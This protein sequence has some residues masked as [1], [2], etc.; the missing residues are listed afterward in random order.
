MRLAALAFAFLF[1]TSVLEAALKHGD[2]APPIEITKWV[3]G[4]AVDLQKAREKKVV[5][6]EFW[7][8]WCGPCRTSIP[9]LTELQKKYRKDLVIIGV[10]KRDPNNSLEKVEAFV[11]EW[12]DKMDY[13]VAFDEPGKVYEAYMTAAKQDGIP[14]A[15]VIDKAGRLAWLGHPNGLDEPLE[16]I[17]AGTFDIQK[18]AREHEL[19]LQV[20]DLQQ[21][22]FKKLQG[23]DLEGAG[24]DGE[25][26]VE[27]SKDDAGTLNNVS[28]MLL[29]YPPAKGKFQKLALAAAARCHELTKGENWMYLD[30]LALATFEAG[31]RPEAVK[32]QEKA[33][34]LAGKASAPEPAIA[35]LK[36]RL[37][38]FKKD[39][40]KE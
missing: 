26:I 3:R 29:T 39:S 20:Q 22:L 14:T 7:A 24:K 2:A 35:E 9:H 37:E 10:T 30:T 13:T 34:E 32:L 31:K 8:T 38:S 18:A 15:F 16:Q 36:G 27:L 5:V 12:G 28:W 17:L 11:R 23:K 40:G 1:S 25:K 19:R 4:E 6:L 33:I 21:S